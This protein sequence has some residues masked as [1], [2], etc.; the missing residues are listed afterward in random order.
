V[1]RRKLDID[2]HDDSVKIR[3]FLKEAI[4]L[5]FICKGTNRESE[6]S[7]L[8]MLKYC[9]IIPFIAVF[10]LPDLVRGFTAP[11]TRDNNRCGL[12]ARRAG[13]KSEVQFD[14]D[15]SPIYECQELGRRQFIASF[16]GAA[17]FLALSESASADEFIS[18]TTLSVSSSDAS[19]NDPKTI[20]LDSRAIFDKA[21]KKALG[22]EICKRAKKLRI[23]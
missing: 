5:N 8:T 15:N 7:I 4:I 14:G 17:S 18:T 23:P 11:R 19:A 13:T 2:I 22:G 3:Y 20:S 9:T 21:A 12:C 10:V 1:G 16:V 6:T